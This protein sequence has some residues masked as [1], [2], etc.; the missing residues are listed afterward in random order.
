MSARNDEHCTQEAS[1]AFVRSP[2][3]GLYGSNLASSLRLRV[4]L[5]GLRWPRN[6]KAHDGAM[7]PGLPDV[8]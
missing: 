8:R 6:D 5:R 3:A 2:N 1:F 7:P 4:R